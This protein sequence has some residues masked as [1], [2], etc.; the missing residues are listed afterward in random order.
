[1]HEAIRQNLVCWALAVAVAVLGGCSR[2]W[3]AGVGDTRFLGLS[4]D[5]VGAGIIAGLI[6]WGGQLVTLLWLRRDVDRAHRRITDHE[7]FYHRSKSR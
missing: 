2:V 1:V 5:A 6:A 4:E 3:A 7:N